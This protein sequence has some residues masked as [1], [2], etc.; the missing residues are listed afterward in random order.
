MGA[1]RSLL[2]LSTGALAGLLISGCTSWPSTAPDPRAGQ[3]DS[4]ATVIEVVDGDTL[5]VDID[6]SEER[7]RLIGIDTPETV[8]PDRPVECFGPEASDHLKSLLPPGTRVRLER[9]LEARD[10]YGRLLV[11]AY[12]A[13]DGLNVNLAQ[14]ETGH[15]ETLTYPPNTTFESALARAEHAARDHDVGIWSAC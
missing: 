10:Q 7:V 5:V 14:V 11:Y 4:N 13:E 2:T 9:D 1:P 6:G 12:R 3:G 15:A 8:A